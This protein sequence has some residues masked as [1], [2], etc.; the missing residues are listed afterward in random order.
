M[1]E[2]A[3]WVWSHLVPFTISNQLVGL[4]EDKVN[5][6]YRPLPSRRISLDDA[7]M[8]HHVGHLQPPF[9]LLFALARCAVVE[10]GD[11]RVDLPI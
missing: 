11:T 5:K 9:A 4:E 1:L 8:D 3:L 2:A 7:G 10:L 6:A